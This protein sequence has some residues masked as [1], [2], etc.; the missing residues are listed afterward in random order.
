MKGCD[1]Y[2]ATIQL[3]LDR[4]LSGQDC[5]FQ[6]YLAYY[7]RIIWRS[8][9]APL[10]HEADSPL[11][12]YD[13]NSQAES[14]TYRFSRAFLASREVTLSPPA[15]RLEPNGYAKY[16]S[17][18]TPHSDQSYTYEAFGKCG[19]ARGTLWQ[20]LC[21]SLDLRIH[22]TFV[23]SGKRQAI[24]IYTPRGITSSQAAARHR[25]DER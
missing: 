14:S 21:R 2:S 24:Y 9:G 8:V 20:S 11:D 17:N 19:E 13:W 15:V 16:L 7:F 22:L 1:D 25:A 3:Y 5:C 4:E 12:Q 10:H 18:T 23:L 6:N